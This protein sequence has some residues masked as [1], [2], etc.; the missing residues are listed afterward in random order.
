MAEK[1]VRNLKTFLAQM[2]AVL[3]VFGVYLLLV[4]VIIPYSKATWAI[5]DIT[6]YIES[7]IPGLIVLAVGVLEYLRARR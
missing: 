4:P 2:G 3:I 6:W 5:G 7:T 1:E